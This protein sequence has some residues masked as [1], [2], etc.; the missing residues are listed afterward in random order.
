MICHVARLTRYAQKGENGEVVSNAVLITGAGMEGDFHAQGG[1]RQ[2]SL[3]TAAARQWISAQKKQG[4]CF[5]RYKENILL[6]AASA[7]AL[8]SSTRLRIGEAVIEISGQ[9]K[10]CFEECPLYKREEPCV[11]AGQNLFVKV[12]KGGAVRVGDAV[13]TMPMGDA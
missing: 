7:A 10:H 13:E 5:R 2:I 3:L 4:L 8:A 6:D 9:G 11:L 12:I 1:E